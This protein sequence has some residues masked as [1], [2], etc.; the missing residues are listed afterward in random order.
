MKRIYKSLSLLA[1]FTALFSLTGLSQNAWINEIHY[2]NVGTDV[3]EFIEVVIQN[4]GSYALSDFS[5]VLYNGNGGTLYDST[6]LDLY[7]VGATTN[8]FTFYYYN[9][10]ANG[11]II[12]NGGSAGIQ[13]D[14]LALVYQGVVISGQWLSYEGA[15][16]AIDGPASGLTSVNMGVMED[17]PVPPEGQSL[18]LSGTGTQYADFSWQDPNTATPGELN[19]DQDLG[20]VGL[21][22]LTGPV[23]TINPNP[24][25]GTFRLFNPYNEEV[26]ISIYSVYGQPVAESMIN[27]GDNYLALNDVSEGIYLLRYCS[28][29]GKIQKTERMIISSR[30]GISP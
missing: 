13:P 2:D 17:S 19:N 23:I 25:K 22:E 11:G 7:S 5:I 29:D 27:P 14:G 6:G 4:P 8:D 1:I 21:H 10:T 3:D 28:K 20:G 15:F 12:Q 26:L 30:Q 18:Q 9:Y 16:A 24:N